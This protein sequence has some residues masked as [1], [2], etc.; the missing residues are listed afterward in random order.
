MLDLKERLQ[1]TLGSRYTIE[2]VIGAG[3]MA[4]VYLAR[5][6]KHDREVALKVLRPELSAVLGSDRFLN[7]IRIAAQLDHPHILTLIDSGEADGLLYYVLPYVRGES[8]RKRLDRE[9]QL[10]VDE[11]LAITRQVAGALDYAH[12][13]GVV[14][15]DVKPENIL[16]HE[17]EA[18]LT[19]FGIAMAVKQAGGNRLTETGLSLGTPQYMSPEQATGDRTLDARSDVYSLAAVL[20]EMLAGEPPHNGPTSQAVI[21]KLMTER[22]T[23]L[24]VVRDTVPEGVDTAVAKAL[25]KVPADRY[26]NA[27]QFS[28]ALETPA[29]QSR[30]QAR[31]WWAAAGV[32]VAALVVLS[33]V[34]YAKNHPA[35]AIP[36]PQRVQLTTN[37]NAF[38]PSLSPDGNRIAFTEK[39]CDAKNHCSYRLVVQDVDGTGR[40]ILTSDLLLV[41]LTDWT[42]DGRFVLYTGVYRGAETYGAYAIPSLGGS[43]RALGPIHPYPFVGDTVVVS[44]TSMRNDSLVWLRYVTVRDGSARDSVAI[45]DPGFAFEG[46]PS[47][48]PRLIAARMYKP[49]TD[50]H[51]LRLIDRSGKMMSRFS[52]GRN[53]GERSKWIPGHSSFLVAVK[54]PTDRDFKFVRVRVKNRKFEPE[55]DTL[56]RNVELVNPTIESWGWFSIAHDG[57]QLLYGGGTAAWSVHAFGV[58]PSASAREQNT[59]ILTSTTFASGR[60]SPDGRRIAVLMLTGIGSGPHDQLFM[61]D[62][63]GTL[64]QLTAPLQDIRGFAWKA[65]G[66]G[67]LMVKLVSP[68]RVSLSEVDTSG[69]E[70]REILRTDREVAAQLRTLRDGTF[71]LVDAAA[72]HIRLFDRTGKKLKEWNSPVFMPGFEIV[73]SDWSDGRHL[74]LVSWDSGFV[75]VMVTRLDMQSGVYSKPAVFPVNVQGWGSL[76]SLDDGRLVLVAPEAG[77]TWGLYEISEKNVRTRLAELPFTSQSAS[78][79]I[80][81]DGRHFT[82]TVIDAKSDIFSIRNFGELLRD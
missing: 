53:I 72:R 65:D 41:W 23:R 58:E 78:Y 63:T 29:M 13:K 59:R 42:P 16:I 48:D 31:R 14:H 9:R 79:T 43:P 51:E 54:G 71:L 76:T 1:A 6:L 20:Y 30:S 8:L 64:R 32:G 81:R 56:L 57:S 2:R 66:S 33:I 52:L 62:S 12:A 80:S 69:R 47:D 35:T 24:R 70:S 46:F 82:A 44:P 19:D 49:E 28:R 37:G 25:A 34:S 21:A 73:A 67:L 22:P 40:L 18:I 3:G 55:V 11:A 74:G 5:D 77:G 36:P 68:D 75:H 38:I 15:R 17:G 61:T 39:E 50:S 4:T 60:I 10:S 45:R 7:E 26:S 27:G